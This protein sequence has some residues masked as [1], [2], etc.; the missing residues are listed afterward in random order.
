MT[1]YA[2]AVHGE[3]KRLRLAV[4]SASVWRVGNLREGTSRGASPPSKISVLVAGSSDY[5]R[6]Q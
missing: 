1:T 4:R 5:P 6:M 3:N 2:V